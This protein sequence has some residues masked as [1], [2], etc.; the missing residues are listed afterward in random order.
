MRVWITTDLE[1][2][3]GVYRWE[4][5]R[6]YDSRAN[7]EAR[8]LLMGEVNAA[9]AGAFDGGAKRVVVWDGHDGS[10]SFFPEELDSRAEMIMGQVGDRKALL[11]QGFDCGILL[12]YHSMS[13]TA[14]GVLCHTQNSVAWNHLWINGRR[15]GEIA[16][17]AISL[18]GFDIP[19]VMVTGDDGA[20]AE[21]RDWLG[22]EIVT[23]QVKQGL[24]REGALMLSPKRAR[25][26][27]RQGVMEAL[28]KAS[29]V[30][31]LKPD[32]PLT[33][34]F[35]FKDSKI[36]DT[37]RGEARTIDACTIEK[38]ISDPDDVFGP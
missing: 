36:V 25:E 8:Q 17:C 24:S 33:L 10:K 5:T 38:E 30:K 3:C 22:E 16:Q 12:G 35:Q 37:Y 26:L 27:I 21:A 13:H 34:R 31:P 20:C 15:A 32:F 28:G 6:D 9:V 18:G 14:G 2:V 19:V 7:L 29:V 11:R 4:Q 23:V 1:G